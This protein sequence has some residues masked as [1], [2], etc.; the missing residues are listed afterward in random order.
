MKMLAES[1]K[2]TKYWNTFTN[3]LLNARCEYNI[4]F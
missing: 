3:R 2:P 4:D 1:Y